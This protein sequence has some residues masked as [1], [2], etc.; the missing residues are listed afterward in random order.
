MLVVQNIK[1]ADI[2]NTAHMLENKNLNETK[3]NVVVHDDHISIVD[4]SDNCL[5]SYIKRDMNA[6]GKHPMPLTY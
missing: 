3:V 5:L 6:P 1:A 4:P 2:I